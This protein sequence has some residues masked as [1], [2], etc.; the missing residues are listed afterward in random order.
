MYIE[1]INSP[2]DIKVLNAEQLNA[3]ASEIRNGLM[4]RL[5]KKE[6]T[7]D[8][9]LDLLKQQLHFTM[10]LIHLKTKLFLT[11]RIKVTF[12]KC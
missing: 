4:N 2:S 11:F 12:I 8:L 10:F 5:S 1:N 7:S 6:D 9:T 3:L